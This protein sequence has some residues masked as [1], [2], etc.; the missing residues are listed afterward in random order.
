MSGPERAAGPASAK[1]SGAGTKD[2]AARPSITRSVAVCGHSR[3]D[4]WAAYPDPA[5]NFRP[6]MYGLRLEEYR[7]EW[8][9]RQAEGWTAFEL[10]V[11]LPRPEVSA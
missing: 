4:L 5:V 8:L 1:L 10:A 7:A 3:P 2:R 9:R 11:R 6:T